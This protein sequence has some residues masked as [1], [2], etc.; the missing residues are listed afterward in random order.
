MGENLPGR[1]SLQV[2]LDV[3]LTDIEYLPALYLPATHGTQVPPLGPDEPA[4]HVQS[5]TESLPDSEYVP[6]GHACL[7]ADPPGQW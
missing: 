5:S 6:A 2:A 1:Q 3:A 4:L 7:S